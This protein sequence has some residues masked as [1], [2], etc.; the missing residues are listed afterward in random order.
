MH[1]HSSAYCLYRQGL[2]KLYRF[3]RMRKGVQNEATE[4]MNV[5]RQGEHS[6]SRMESIYNKACDCGI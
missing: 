1:V 2:L 6:G 3:L 4:I 5:A